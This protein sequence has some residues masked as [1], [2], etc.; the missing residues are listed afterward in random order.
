MDKEKSKAPI[1]SP[2][3]K[4]SRGGGV[5][6]L[7]FLVAVIFI[8]PL[9]NPQVSG[10][11]YINDMTG[12]SVGPGNVDGLTS[13]IVEDDG[14]SVETAP[15]YRFQI[16]RRW[17]LGQYEDLYAQGGRGEPVGARFTYTGK[18]GGQATL[19]VSPIRAADPTYA[20]VSAKLTYG[21]DKHIDYSY[22]NDIY[23]LVFGE[24]GHYYAIYDMG[25][26]H[27]F[28]E[29]TDGTDG[30]VSQLLTTLTVQRD[31]DEE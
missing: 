19:L 8:A 6:I 7:I 15:G 2:E 22:F 17:A 13:R 3:E 24:D 9:V 30:D 18:K 5:F 11:L 10:D 25:E 28:L 14:T 23:P 16:P 29:V 1:E 27:F 26:E 20:L 12:V 4:R 21:S 31:E